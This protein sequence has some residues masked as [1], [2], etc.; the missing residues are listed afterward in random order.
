MTIEK[1]R[2]PILF[3]SLA[4]IIPW[5]FWFA[6]GYLSHIPSSNN[7][8]VVVASILGFLGLLG[9]MVI[10]FSMILPD[11]ELRGDLF[12]RLF[13][14]KKIKPIYLFLT[15]FLMLISILLA[16]AIS[17]LFGYSIDQ[18]K[19]SGGTF[20]AGIFS[21]WFVLII[22]PIIEEL[23]WHTY[24]TDC[25]R[26][27][28]S[29]FKTSIMFAVFWAIW[30]FPLSGIKGYYQA[31]LVESWIYSL[32]FAVSLIP[33]V[34]LMNWLYYKTNRNIFVAIVFHISAGFFNEIFLTH[35]D[36][37]IIQTLLL[38]LLTIIIVIRERKFFFQQE[39]PE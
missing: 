27:R 33:Y 6:A 25:L 28:F 4:T 30:H 12:N 36:S 34:L 16:Q 29:L 24:G 35:P 5:L 18:F 31:N 26:K 7:L 20:T 39:Y 11:Q 21:V 3:Y 8:Y 22:A 9:P 13:S 1:Y 23:A 10:A 14:M 2:H 38:L 32:N 37:K 15:F 19:L 17:L